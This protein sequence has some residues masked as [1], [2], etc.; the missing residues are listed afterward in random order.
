MGPDPLASGRDGELKPL[1][2]P[3][4]THLCGPEGFFGAA[5]LGHQNSQLQP[6]LLGLKVS[7]NG[8]HVLCW[9]LCKSK[10]GLENFS[11]PGK[12]LG[13]SLCELT[14]MQDI[15]SANLNLKPGI[16]C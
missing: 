16:L 8:S 13:F 14:R 6:V 9:T 2:T 7:F 10:G 4:L 11:K 1:L 5:F 3:C 12:G 15:D